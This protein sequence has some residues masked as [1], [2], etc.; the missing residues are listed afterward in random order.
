MSE[1]LSQLAEG[2]KTPFAAA[3]AETFHLPNTL[4]SL[5]L[6]FFRLHTHTHPYIQTK[7]SRSVLQ[8]LI[9]F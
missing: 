8:Y 4:L 2:I 7:A 3:E 5:S 1:C 9:L 6:L